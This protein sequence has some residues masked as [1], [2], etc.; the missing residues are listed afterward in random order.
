[1]QPIYKPNEMAQLQSGSSGDYYEAMA[2]NPG[3]LLPI[4]F[5]GT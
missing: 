1:M 4:M 5:P 3:R 2:V